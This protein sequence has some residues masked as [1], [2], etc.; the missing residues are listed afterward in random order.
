MVP[1]AL[2]AQDACSWYEVAQQPWCLWVKVYRTAIHTAG[3]IWGETVVPAWVR[4]FDVD[5]LTGTAQI[6]PSLLIVT[7][8]NPQVVKRPN[9]ASEKDPQLKLRPADQQTAPIRGTTAPITNPAETYASPRAESCLTAVG[10]ICPGDITVTGR[11]IEAWRGAQHSDS[12]VE[13]KGGCM[14]GKFTKNGKLTDWN[15]GPVSYLHDETQQL[16]KSAE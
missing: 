1:F 10:G 9:H 15:Q 6:A 2:H 13:G 11:S 12:F 8:I 16:W 7:I 14:A 4:N 5:H 3:V